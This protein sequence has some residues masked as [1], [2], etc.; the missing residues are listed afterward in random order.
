MIIITTGTVA[1]TIKI[2]IKKNRTAKTWIKITTL[3]ITMTLVARGCLRAS[4]PRTA[5]EG[6][7][8]EVS[9]G[10]SATKIW[11]LSARRPST[12]GL[13]YACF[14]LFL[15]IVKG[16]DIVISFLLSSSFKSNFRQ[17]VIREALMLGSCIVES[18]GHC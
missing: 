18:L 10:R 13:N 9:E 7:E 17:G 6:Q 11:F 12:P 4:D 16:V 2:K 8:R 14:F 5:F 1:T 3:L 15:R